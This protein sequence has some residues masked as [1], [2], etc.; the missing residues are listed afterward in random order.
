MREENM[1]TPIKKT[2]IIWGCLIWTQWTTAT[3]FSD[4]FNDEVNLLNNNTT[5][6]SVL[7]AGVNDERATEITMAGGLLTFIPEVFELNAWFEDEYGPLVYQT[8]S[9]NFVAVI[10]LR[11]SSGSDINQPPEVG[12]NAGGFVIRDASGTHNND[13]N[14]VMYNMGGQ[15][16]NGVT[17]AREMKKTVNSVSNLFL[18]EQ[19]TLEA[20][21]LACRVGD[22]FYFY[23]WADEVGAWRQETFYNNFTVDG[24]PT[25]TWRNS[26]SVTPE[27]ISAGAGQAIPMHFNHPDMPV[28]VQI[29][30]MGH[31]W[32]NN[33]QGIRADY[34]YIRFADQIP[35]TQNDCPA[36]FTA[37]DLLDD[38]IFTDG[39]ETLD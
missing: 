8:I 13:E 29:G 5:A 6:W 2:A 18:T 12:F 26:S 31:T 21:L 3:G 28:D 22:D 30:I 35:L 38:L 23:Y 19:V 17:Y 4:E 7:G 20:Y 14:W 27:V 25:T 15:G 9:G 16:M 24:I 11:V 36:A 32:T 33:T 37:N 10:N 39:F 1:T 34:E